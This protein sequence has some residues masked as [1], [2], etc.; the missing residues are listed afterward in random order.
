M[1]SSE[2]EWRKL[3]DDFEQQWNF[4]KCVGAV[5]GKHVVITAPPNSGSIYYNYKHTHSIVLMAICDANYKFLYIDVGRNGRQSD[6]GIFNKCS[7]ATALDDG[8]LQLPEPRALAGNELHLPYVVVADDAFAL[9]TNVMKPYPGRNLNPSQR[10]FNYRLSRARRVIE[11]A[12]GIMCSK[13]RVMHSPILLDAEK[14][15]KVTLA[16]CALHN[17]LI[18][19]KSIAYAPTSSIDQRVDH[20]NI[21]EGQWRNEIPDGTMYP[22]ER[23]PTRYISANAKKVRENFESYFMSADG[24]VPWQFKFI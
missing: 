12:F 14:A 8:E 3:A 20:G 6:G 16:C 7:F 24:E 2:H 17:F 23:D 11:N 9:R 5:D 19:R 15:R 21:S 1:A 18:S 13:F 10:I 22:L 4:P